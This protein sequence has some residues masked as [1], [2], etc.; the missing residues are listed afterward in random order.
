MANYKK[1]F[2]G[3]GGV[4]LKEQKVEQRESGLSVFVCVHLSDLVVQ[5]NL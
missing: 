2:G 4:F 5:H 3:K 1:Q